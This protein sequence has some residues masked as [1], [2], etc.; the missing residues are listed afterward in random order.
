MI[1]RKRGG[2]GVK[3]E[4]CIEMLGSSL[5]S[6]TGLVLAAVVGRLYWYPKL[7]EVSIYAP[8]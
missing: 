8:K 5:V 7:D 3:A 2:D 4:R 6:E 1:R